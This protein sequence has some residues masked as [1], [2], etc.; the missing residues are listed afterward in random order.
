MAV[1][2]RAD[3]KVLERQLITDTVHVT[4]VYITLL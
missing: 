2:P 3:K 4:L 1:N